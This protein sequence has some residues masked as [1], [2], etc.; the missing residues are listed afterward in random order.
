MRKIIIFLLKLPS[1]EPE[2]RTKKKSITPP[3]PDRSHLT[4]ARVPGLPL[5]QEIVQLRPDR[6][7]ILPQAGRAAHLLLPAQ[8]VLLPLCTKIGKYQRETR[9]VHSRSQDVADASSLLCHKDTAQDTQSI[10]CLSLCVSELCL[11]GIKTPWT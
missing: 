9:L 4:D 11:Y 10:S 1:S 8:A 7:H 5:H 6:H 2:P 3:R